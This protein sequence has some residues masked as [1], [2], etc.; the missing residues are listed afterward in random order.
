[1]NKKCVSPI[2]A[3]SL[4]LLITAF[5]YVSLDGWYDEFLSREVINY[6]EQAKSQSGRSEILGVENG[7]LYFN[8][9]VKDNLTINE[10]KVNGN[11][12]MLNQNLSYGINIINIKS[13]FLNSNN[14]SDEILILTN[15]SVFSKKV[16]PQK[17]SLTPLNLDLNLVSPTGHF[18]SYKNNFYNLIFNL[19]CSGGDCGNINL[20]FYYEV[21]Q[22]DWLD[23]SWINRKEIT[24]VG[25]GNL[26]DFPL[27]LKVE[28]ETNMN[29]D[30][31]D[32]RFYNGSCSSQEN[33]FLESDLEFYNSSQA[34]FWIKFPNLNSNNKICMYYGNSL[35]SSV[36]NKS[37]VWD[38]NYIS[39]YHLNHISGDAID[40]KGNFNAQENVAPDSNLDVL[41]VVGRADYFDGDDYLGT[42]PEWNADGAHTYCTWVKYSLGHNG[43]ILED[44]GNT[45]GHGFAVLPNGSIRYA[46]M[47]NGGEVFVESP[48]FYNDDNW[49]HT[50]GGHDGSTAYLYVDGILVA[51]SNNGDGL[52]GSD[53][54]RIGSGNGA[55][56][57]FHDS[58]AHFYNGYLDELRV[59]SIMRSSDWINQSYQLIKNQDSLVIFGGEEIYTPSFVSNLIPLGSGSV[60]YTNA[61]S[62]PKVIFNLNE[63]QNTQIN[64]DLNSTDNIGSKYNIFAYAEIL[65][66]STINIT[67]DRL[68]VTISEYS[69]CSLDGITVGHGNNDFFYNSSTVPQGSTCSG[70]TR[71][72]TN[73]VLDGDNSYNYSSCH[74]LQL[75]MVPTFAQ[76]FGPS[77][78]SGAGVSDVAVDSNDNIYVIGTSSSN[79]NDGL[80]SFSG[81]AGGGYI[82]KFDSTGNSVWGRWVGGY[83]FTS[84]VIDNDEN[85]IVGGNAQSE[86]TGNSL[87]P[88]SGTF[89]AN[90]Y[91]GYIAK[92]DSDGNHLWGH[93]V[94]GSSRNSVNN[95]AVNSLNEIV[96]VG[97]SDKNI[98]DDG[99][100][101][102]GAYTSSYEGFA[103]KFNSSGSP[104]WAQWF[105]GSEMDFTTAVAFDNSDN[106]YIGGRARASFSDDGLLGFTGTYSGEEEVFISKFDVNNNNIWNR[107]IGGTQGEF[108]DDM[109]F[110]NENNL[111]LVGDSA[112]S[113]FVGDSLQSFKGTFS[114]YSEIFIMKFDVDGNNIWN[115]WV[116]SDYDS[117]G[118]HADQAYFIEFDSNNDFYIGGN[119]GDV[120]D[121]IAIPFEGVFTP[122]TYTWEAYAIK[123]NSSADA[124]WA[125]WFGGS[126]YDEVLGVVE[127]DNGH[128]YVIGQANKAMSD[129]NL[130]SFNGNRNDD[131]F[132]IRFEP[133]WQ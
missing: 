1:M 75:N 91:E 31:S 6:D 47:Y 115:Q 98:T 116:G 12:C 35:A 126:D 17:V 54:A 37:A 122:P 58:N 15:N 95:L 119:M 25:G 3:I 72:C 44:G 10:I 48:L 94:G 50:C 128:F 112:S 36:E 105:G 127:M 76:W 67:S 5:A 11:S 53:N 68:N 114:G 55:N 2:A 4:I 125:H 20:N 93:Y 41:G 110:D 32:I 42:N 89:G 39:V 80:V 73:G 61:S 106:L 18:N 8:N 52:A 118:N 38:S 23:S 85:V 57:A 108:V 79:F 130:C 81:S 62:N 59:S 82:L 70:I 69:S 29:V 19:S 24:I 121:D 84:I 60:V 129:D 131:G 97:S 123:F 111:H 117:G 100:I 124:L 56:G 26:N 45:D 16:P 87:L 102:N 107:W 40:I 33:N 99:I 77:D 28:K 65:S 49:H 109:N 90:Y 133:T 96:I 101:F 78:G 86:M 103:I 43:T 113:T 88:F 9:Y 66:D 64:L 71:T 34:D 22:S 7:K 46:E 13:C 51:S 74:I 92:F 30:Y 21:D 14:L 27:F 83:R 63:D 104:N 120:I 132:I